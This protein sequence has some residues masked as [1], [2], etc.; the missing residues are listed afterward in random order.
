LVGDA[1]DPVT[2]AEDLL[3]HDDD[4]GLLLALGEDDVGVEFLV[5][6]QVD[7]RV[8]AVARGGV[9]PLLGAFLIRRKIRGERLGG[10]KR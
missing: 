9:Q 6:A 8:L 4:R 1:A 3:D 7:L 5:V 10:Q 2:E